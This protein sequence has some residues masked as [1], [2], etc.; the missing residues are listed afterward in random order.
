[1]W[2]SDGRDVE[3]AAEPDGQYAYLTNPEGLF[4]QPLSPGAPERKR[5]CELYKFMGNLM[6]KACR[7]K[8]TVPLPLHPH[9]FAVLKGGHDLD[10][11]MR[12][13]GRESA[14]IPQ[15]EDWT[16]MDLLRA[17]ADM[18]ASATNEEELAALGQGEFTSA[19]LSRTY[20]CTLEDFL[21]QSGAK[22]VDPLTGDALFPGGEEQDL[23]VT[24]LPE[25]V[26]LVADK[27]FVSGIEAQLAAFREGLSA[28]FPSS[29]LNIF[30]AAELSVMLCGEKTIEWNKEML[31][32]SLKLVSNEQVR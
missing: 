5:V 14:D 30:G 31:E 8:F 13:F 12:S 7:D 24:R 15:G 3:A 26:R 19:R 9:F 28:I 1:M 18:C 32:K 2:V 21:S 11:L 4:P 29:A 17:Y 25:F 20:A 10:E 23:V 6:G 16:S 27:W 22:F